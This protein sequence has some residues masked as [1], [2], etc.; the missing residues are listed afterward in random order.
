MTHSGGRVRGIKKSDLTEE[1]WAGCRIVA[2]WDER[3]HLG[4][5]LVMSRSVAAAQP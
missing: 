1:G 5:Q 4:I 2:S 3:S